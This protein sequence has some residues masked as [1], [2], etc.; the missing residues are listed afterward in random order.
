MR[1]VLIAL[2]VFALAAPAAAQT[3]PEPTY[4][5]AS[6]AGFNRFA[7]PQ[8]H[9]WLSLGV[10][11]SGGY[12]SFSTVD[13]TSRVATMRTGVARLLSREGRLTLIG[14]VDAG[15]AGGGEEFGAAFSGGAIVAYD[16][17]RLLRATGVHVTAGVRLA[18]TTLNELQPALSFGIAKTFP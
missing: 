9:G 11:V 12:Y 7:D 8:T 2:L 18:K 4:W 3:E 6:G 17:G 5:I 10:R 14:L 15:V 13:M 16:L 1:F